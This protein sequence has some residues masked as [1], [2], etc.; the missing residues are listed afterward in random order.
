MKTKILML[1]FSIN[2]S[3]MVYAQT[4]STINSVKVAS[5][6]NRDVKNDI[7]ATV[8]STDVTVL[9]Q[10]VVNPMLNQP[11]VKKLKVK[12]INDGT[13]IAFLIEWTDSTK[14]VIVDVDK[15]C[16][17]LAIQLPIN[18]DTIPVFMM[19]NKKGRVHIIHWKAVWQNDIENGFRDV[20]EAYPNY[21]ADIYPMA[22]KQSDGS[23]EKFAKDI[24]ILDYS[25]TAGNNFL[26][27]SY[28][29]NPMSI[30]DRKDPSEEC[31]AESYG[32]LTTQTSQ[33]AT[34]WGS[35]DSNTWQVIFTRPLVSSDK[36]D[37][38]LSKPTKIAFAVW[39]GHFDNISGKKHYSQWIDLIIQK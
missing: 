18:P 31:I 38:P 4:G 25:K 39:N 2:L 1:L 21:W 34:A 35:W 22:E 30:F 13:T 23:N 26:P 32:T 27:G 20:K 3:V 33:N 9:P 19:G 6:A 37:A 11:S 17:Q 29:G 12:S 15:F 10:N 7:W 28:A 24:K 5:V 14:D 16:D 36:N 8:Q